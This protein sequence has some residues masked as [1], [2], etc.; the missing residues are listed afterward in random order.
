MDSIKIEIMNCDSIRKADAIGEEQAILIYNAAYEMGDKIVI[1]FPKA[2]EF[3]CIRIDD[4][5][6]ETYV[7]IANKELVYEIPFEEKKAAHNPKSFLGDVHYITCRLARSYEKQAYRNLAFNVL[8]QHKDTG[9]YP[10]AIANVETRGES[11]FAARNAI[12][13]VLANTYHGL[14][15]FQSWGI[16]KNDDAELII[17]FGRAVDID[18]I[19]LY[20]RADF[21]HDNWW[22]KANFD[23]S[24]GSSEIVEMEKSIKPHEFSMIKKEI[25]WIKLYHL[26]KSKDP[27]PFPAL[28][29]IEVYGTEA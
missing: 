23:F 16:N 12:D 9:C 8:D 25:R 4:T 21:P 13:G 29:Q 24:D 17:D 20:T 22:T 14:W 11:I 6:D 19:I 7:Y 28:T 15:P 1:N 3:Y 5:L 26:L 10:H 2:N 27:S 18:K